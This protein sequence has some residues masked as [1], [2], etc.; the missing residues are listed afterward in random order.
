MKT[1]ID[2]TYLPYL[3]RNNDVNLNI[4]V[5][6][7]GNTELNIEIL[8]EKLLLSLYFFFMVN[9]LAEYRDIT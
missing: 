7:D 5:D 4:A 8:N 3:Y 9:K 6:D 2:T 1:F